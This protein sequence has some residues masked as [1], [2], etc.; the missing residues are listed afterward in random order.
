[1][2]SST[3]YRADTHDKYT[4]YPEGYM[5]IRASD[6]ELNKSDAINYTLLRAQGL[7]ELLELAYV[8]WDSNKEI[9]NAVHTPSPEVLMACLQNL[10][11]QLHQ[12]EILTNSSGI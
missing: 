11:G 7:I 3:E 2:K 4:P 9:E 5:T 6:C 8:N 12:L 10:K 1:M